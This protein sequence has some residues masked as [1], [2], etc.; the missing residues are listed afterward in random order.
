MFVEN[1]KK[2][3]ILKHILKRHLFRNVKSSKDIYM[4]DCNLV[5]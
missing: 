4:N 3:L 5:P 1:C 2:T